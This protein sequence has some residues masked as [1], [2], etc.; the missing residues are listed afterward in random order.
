MLHYGQTRIIVCTDE[1]D[2]GAR[3]AAAVGARMRELLAGQQE[4]RMV[5]AAGES[6]IT[7]LAALCQ[8]P[9]I[10][11][12]RVVCF[13]MDDFWDPRMPEQ[14]TCGHQTQTQLYEKVGPRQFHLVRFNAADP[15]A[16]AQRFAGLL[17]RAGAIDILCQGIGTSGHLALN[18]PGIT[19]FDD[20]ELVRVVDLAE[21]SKRQLR[22]D[23]NFKDL[24][25][26]PG[27]GITMTIP[28]LL[29][30][31]DV[32][33]MVPL[34]LKREILTRMVAISEPTSELPATILHRTPGALYVDR[35]S[36]PR[37]LL[38]ES[39]TESPRT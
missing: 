13:N 11:W 9:G 19:D 29:S 15:E 18:E 32:F 37:H 38:E 16:E 12:Q 26:I 1:H 7:F 27:K 24:G 4:I 10:D 25:Y 14:F 34:A 2:L 17:S 35:N 33:T 20:R 21:Q 23:P 39:E 28:A 36:C 6:Q 31:A 22:A 3:A 5:F 8:Q 30:A